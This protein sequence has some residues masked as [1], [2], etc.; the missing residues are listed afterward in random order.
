LALAYQ[1]DETIYSGFPPGI[2]VPPE[3]IQENYVNHS[4]NG[5]CWYTSDHLLISFRDIKEGEE[6]CYDYALTE[7]NPEFE[8]KCLCK[9]PLCRHIIRGTDYQLKDIQERYAG[10]FLSHVQK[11]I[12]KF[13]KTHSI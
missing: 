10:H 4:C 2:P 13:N 7:T 5:N 12:D 9:S 1:V 3:V 8:L 6:I 11:S